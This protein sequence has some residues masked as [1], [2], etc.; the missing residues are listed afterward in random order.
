M[1]KKINLL[2][3]KHLVESEFLILSN[4]LSSSKHK[5]QFGINSNRSD[6]K[7]SFSLDV[8]E[9]VK[10]LK[11][12]VRILQFLGQQ[13]NKKLNVCSSTRYI[14][15]FLKL[16]QKEYAT[17]SFITVQENSS[18][19]KNF[20]KGVQSFIVLEESHNTT[21][22]AIKRLVEENI[23]IISKIN[24][25]LESNHNGTYKIHNDLFNYKKLTFLVALINTILKK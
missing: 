13:T 25:R 16:Y 11:Q 20:Y 19:I 8:F 10:T 15:S 1:H 18:D 9:L 17:K 23:L 21:I 22:P 14:A 2:L 4:D 5:A 3:F 6:R 12:L 24:S 7:I